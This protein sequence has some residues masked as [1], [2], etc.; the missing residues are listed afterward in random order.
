MTAKPVEPIAF[1]DLNAQR[2]VLGNKVNK[3]LDKIVDSCAFIM[4]PEVGELENKL[5]TYCGVKH[6]LSCASGTDALVLALMAK[7]VGVGDAVFVPSFTFVATAEAVVLLGATP[8]FVDVRPDTFNMDVEDLKK[9]ISF[10]KKSGLNLKAIIPVDIFGQPADYDA[11]APIAKDEN[12]FIISDAAQSFGATLNGKKVGNIVDITCTSFFP[13]KPLGCYGDG[14]AVFYNDDNLVEPLKS[15]RIHGMGKEKYDN[16]RIGI[17]GRL[18]TMQAAI[19]LLK[20]DIFDDE[21][22]QRNLVAK[23]YREGLPMYSHQSVM[24]N[25]TSVW[26]QYTMLTDRRDELQA[27]LKEKGVPTAAYYPKPVHMQT[28][29]AKYS[30]RALPVCERLA[31]QVISPPMHP[32]MNENTQDYIIESFK[33]F[34]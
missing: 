16:I 8:V 3:A 12:M 7:D 31:E 20:M 26:A 10:A 25:A 13:A 24:S 6:T 21:L 15:I 29:Y 32:Y 30:K 9:A 27:F 17:N 22:P 19:L 18:D 2:K 34:K 23:K 1:I 5:S 28:A 11:I 33:A 4:G 14:G